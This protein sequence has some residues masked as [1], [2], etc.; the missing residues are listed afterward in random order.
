M[1]KAEGFL[2]A[3]PSRK[4]SDN[5]LKDCYLIVFISIFPSFAAAFSFLLAQTTLYIS[6]KDT[7]PKLFR[8]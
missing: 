3:R 5:L 7:H 2:Y 6:H 4:P 8:Q 1:K